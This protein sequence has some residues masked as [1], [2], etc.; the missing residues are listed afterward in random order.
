MTST[1]SAR[2][3]KTTRNIPTQKRA[4]QTVAKLKDTTVAL[5]AK[6]PYQ[7]ITTNQI[8]REANISI[9]SLYKYYPNKEALLLDIATDLIIKASEIVKESVKNHHEKSA[10]ELFMFQAEQLLKLGALPSSSYL[11][12]IVPLALQERKVNRLITDQITDSVLLYL[13][14]NKDRY[15]PKNPDITAKTISVAT[16]AICM[17]HLEDEK[18]LQQSKEDIDVVPKLIVEEIAKLIELM[19]TH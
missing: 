4:L 9:G 10:K 12:F 18:W 6:Q 8:A 7:E 3:S 17:N 2:T 16:M 13:A 19:L 11:S 1:D 15:A 5:L 14:Y